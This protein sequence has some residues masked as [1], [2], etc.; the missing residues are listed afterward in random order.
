MANVHLDDFLG[1]VVVWDFVQ[2]ERMPLSG[3]KHEHFLQFRELK[4]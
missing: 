4:L 3:T 2:Q 1:N